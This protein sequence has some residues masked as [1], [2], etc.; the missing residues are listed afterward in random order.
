MTLRER[1]FLHPSEWG[2]WLFAH[3]AGEVEGIG[4]KEEVE[5]GGVSEV[6]EGGWRWVGVTV[7]W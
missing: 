3:L 7:G 6:T 2:D 5:V 1:S 4:M